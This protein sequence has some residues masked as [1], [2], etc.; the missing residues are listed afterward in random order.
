LGMMP[1][2]SSPPSARSHVM[3]LM[4]PPT[5]INKRTSRPSQPCRRCCQ[6]PWEE[7]SAEAVNAVI[8]RRVKVE[9]SESE[10]RVGER[11][12]HPRR[13]WSGFEVK[14]MT[15]RR[16]SLRHSRLTWQSPARDRSPRTL[17]VPS[18]IG[19]DITKM[20]CNGVAVLQ[21]DAHELTRLVIAAS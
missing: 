3:A 13:A 5:A 7:A 6:C 19:L 16:R 9:L 21:L 12:D 2:L 18:T 11:T 10:G 1:N 20:G 14:V 8:R 17:H 4:R 15:L